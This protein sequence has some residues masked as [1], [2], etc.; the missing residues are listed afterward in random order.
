[1]KKFKDIADKATAT[2]TI[3]D[4]DETLFYTHAK[5]AVVKDGKTVKELDNKTFNTYTLGPGEQFD[6]EQFKSAEIFHKTSQPIK[7]MITKAK[8]IVHHGCRNPLSK[9]IIL[10]ARANLDDRDLFLSTFH[11]YGLDIDKM[12]VERSGNLMYG[13]T[14]QKKVYIIEKYLKQGIFRKARM[15]DD[16][17]SNLHAFIAM[18][19][20]YPHV[21]FEAYLVHHDGSISKYE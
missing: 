6:Y 4:L 3:F 20:D 2:L 16:A 21:S 11:K 18:R 10:T 5:I 1:M 7:N 13:N 12:W 8:R 17:V 9:N 19:Q 15:F 14:A